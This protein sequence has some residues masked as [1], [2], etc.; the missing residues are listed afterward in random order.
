MV[1]R[2]QSTPTELAVQAAM[3]NHGIVETTSI[4]TKMMFLTTYLSCN[5]QSFQK[6]HDATHKSLK[7]ACVIKVKHVS[8]LNESHL[9]IT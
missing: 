7:P 2:S 6:Y 3:E 8:V 9:I 1:V 4:M 5:E